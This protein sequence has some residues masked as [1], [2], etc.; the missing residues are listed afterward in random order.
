MKEIKEL[1]DALNYFQTKS[2]TVSID[3]NLLQK[4]CEE[5]V[6]EMLQ[7]YFTEG[8]IRCIVE[9]RKWVHW[10]IDDYASAISLRSVSPKA[11]MYLRLKLNYPLPS[12]ATLRKWALRTFDIREGFL[13]DVLAVMR[14]KGKGLTSFEKTS[15][16]TFDEMSL[17]PEVCFDSK[18]EKLVGPCKKVQVIMVRGLFSNWKQPIYYKFDQPMTKDILIEAVNRLYDAGYE[19]VAITCDMA[20]KGVWGEL[21]ITPENH[22]FQH[23][24][25]KDAKIFVFADLSTSDKATEKLVYRQRFI[26]AEL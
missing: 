9:R 22:F 11:Y 20:N 13:S 19:V 8:Q 6:K 14:E 2:E 1:K 23:P 12:L 18:I 7:L 21:N 15:V 25:I 17:S 3:K 4:Q 24:V 10:S 16:I 5:Q 26:I